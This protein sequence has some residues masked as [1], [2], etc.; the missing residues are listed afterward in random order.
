MGAEIILIEGWSF[1]L[2]DDGEPRI[3]DI[4]LAMRAGLKK[5]RNIRQLIERNREYIEI[6][7]PLRMRPTVGRISKPNGGYEE[8]KI[9]GFWL[10]ETQAYHVVAK[11]ETPMADRLI[12]L[13]ARAF[14][15]VRRRELPG[16][17]ELASVDLIAQKVAG[18]ILQGQK[19]ILA[20]ITEAETNLASRI[21][22]IR[23]KRPLSTPTKRT[24][25]TANVILGGQC[26]CCGVNPVVDAEGNIL[27]ADFDHFFTPWQNKLYET[28]LI[29]RKVCHADFTARG[30]HDH[31]INIFRAYQ[32]KLAAL[33]PSIVTTPPKKVPKVLP[34]QLPLIST[35]ILVSPEPKSASKPKLRLVSKGNRTSSYSIA[36][37]SGKRIDV[38]SL[39][40]FNDKERSLILAL[41][42]VETMGAAELVQV[43]FDGDGGADPTSKV[44]NSLR[45][46]SCAGWVEKVAKGTYRL[47]DLGRTRSGS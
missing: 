7:G 34:G 21:N 33:L 25:T 35:P 9:N 46:P 6:N 3:Q 10:N 11:L 44:R 1:S 31:K 24:H 47:T 38:P 18:P 45:R 22:D 41:R 29:C 40:K 28:W 19:V 43:A 26:Q 42:G 8:R 32:E 16:G 37:Q 4:E 23:H 2:D 27:D 36:G 20:R 12:P 39:D 15:L 5:P 30:A 13:M 14:T 17:H